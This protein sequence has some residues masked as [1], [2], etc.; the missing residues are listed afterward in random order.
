MVETGA[1]ERLH[2]CIEDLLWATT[3]SGQGVIRHKEM[4]AM[5]DD[6]NTRYQGLNFLSVCMLVGGLGP[7]LWRTSI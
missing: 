4:L 6:N 3:T 5:T 7:E 1:D 2:I